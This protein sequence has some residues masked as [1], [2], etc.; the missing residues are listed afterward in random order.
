ML[1][2]ETLFQLRNLEN[3]TNTKWNYEILDQNGSDLLSSLIVPRIS[4]MYSGGLINKED[5]TRAFLLIFSGR[6][7]SDDAY[8]SL[9]RRDIHNIKHIKLIYSR[10]N[11]DNTSGRFTITLLNNLNEWVEV[12]KFDNNQNLTDNYVWGLAEIDINFKN[13]GII[14][15]YD[16]V[17]SNKQDMA[18][19][20][21][22]LT[23][24]V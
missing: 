19:S 18:I 13:Y 14:L 7:I 5:D 3:R 20:R 10:P 15:K 2:D 24:A 17:K 23:Y 1:T 11:I 4:G 22:I 8:V 16:N 6:M 21:I 12:L 9:E